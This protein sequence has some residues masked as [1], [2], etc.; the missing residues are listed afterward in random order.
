MF[1]LATTQNALQEWHSFKVNWSNY[2]KWQISEN[3]CKM[4]EQRA[5]YCL[6]HPLSSELTCYHQKQR[7]WRFNVSAQNLIAI[8][9]NKFV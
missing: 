9:K 3:D 7:R 1:S 6:S 2:H 8:L 5:A 4:L